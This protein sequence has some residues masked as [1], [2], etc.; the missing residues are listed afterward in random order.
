MKLLYFGESPWVGTGLAQVT[1]NIL[2]P[3]VAD[4]HTVECVAMNHFYEVSEPEKL[5]YVIH[6]CPADDSSN[7]KKAVERIQSGD[8]DAFMYSA[9]FGRHEDVFK[10]LFEEQK[11]REFFSIIYS[12]VDC[13][14]IPP[15]SFSV[16][17]SF[18]VRITYTHHAKRV[19]ESQNPDAGV[20]VIPLACEPDRF[21]PLAPEERRAARRDLFSIEDDDYFL[22]INV[23]R[24]QPRKDLGRCIAIYHQF[25]Q[26]HPHGR[27][28]LHCKH[29][30][31]AGHVPT[32][33]H[34]LGA[35]QECIFTNESFSLFNGFNFE[36]MNRIYNAA[37]CLF[38]T[39]TGEG[40]GLSTTESMCA[41]TP[42]VVPNNTAFTEIVGEH[43]ERGYLVQTG[44]DIDHLTWLYGM[45][46]NPRDAVHAKAAI[47]KLEQV[48][49]HREEA[50]EKAGRAREWCLHNT[51]EQV[52]EQWRNLFRCLERSSQA[53]PDKMAAI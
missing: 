41:G 32:Q 8:Y 4:G 12:P 16:L 53:L 45:V 50:K 35:F 38:S 52:G 49:Q 22:V 5:P 40:W 25:H 20:H 47:A 10:A 37:D 13:D 14:I 36:T 28:Y 7:Q 15:N 31:G 6:P 24:N 27:I 46:D 30:D 43:E 51:K 11:K 3:L 44:G 18:N 34:A 9:D 26:W 17:E 21:Y 42:V 48:Y 2:D 33:A 39:S 23:N 19:I 29:Q 1:R